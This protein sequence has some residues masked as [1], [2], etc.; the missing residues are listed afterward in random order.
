MDQD[1]FFEV[2]DASKPVIIAFA[3]LAQQLS[4]PVFEFKNFFHKHFDCNFVFC[5]DVSLSWYFTGIRNYSSRIDDTVEKLKTFINEHRFKKVITLGT[6]AGG[7]AALLFGNLIGADEIIS[8]CPQTF[9]DH[10]NIKH[11]GENRWLENMLKVESKACPNELKYLDLSNLPQPKARRVTVLLGMLEEKDYAHAERIK[12][13]ANVNVVEIPN[14]NHYNMMK[15]LRNTGKLLK[16]LQE[17]ILEGTA[18]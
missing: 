1:I 17:H 15:V 13:W 6:S 18:S 12:K 8:F 3:G 5:K 16:I 14:A 9:I 11:Y 4:E 7:F 2:S 10:E